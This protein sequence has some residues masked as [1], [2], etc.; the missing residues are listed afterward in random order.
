MVKYLFY[1]TADEAQDNIWSYT[2]GKWGEKQAEK[3]ITNLHKHLQSLA[4]KDKIWRSLPDSINLNKQIYFSRYEHHYIFFKQFKNG[5][6]G[7]LSIL[8]KKSDIP[9]HLAN[10]LEKIELFSEDKP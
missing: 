3:Y 7:I 8:H 9:V 4:D 10:D 2:C 5:N 1:S 6:I